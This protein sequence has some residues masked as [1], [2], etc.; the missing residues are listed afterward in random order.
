MDF[1][2]FWEQRPPDFVNELGTKWWFDKDT[3]QFAVNPDRNDVSLAVN[4]WVIEDSSGYRTRVMINS[5]N[6]VIEE[7]Q[8]LEGMGVKIDV[9]KFLKHEDKKIQHRLDQVLDRLKDP[10]LSKKEAH[11]LHDERRILQKQLE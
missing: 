8:S 5:D 11:A 7:D 10:N 4:V 6:E 1:R 9:R 2:P 3:T